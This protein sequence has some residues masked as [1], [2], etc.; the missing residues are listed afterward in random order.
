MGKYQAKIVARKSL[1]SKV[2]VTKLSDARAARGLKG[3]RGIA[4]RRIKGKLGQVA[5]SNSTAADCSDW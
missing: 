1:R 5:I 3:F 2:A 4:T